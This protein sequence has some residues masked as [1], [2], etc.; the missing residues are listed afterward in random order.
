MVRGR[1]CVYMSLKEVYSIQRHVERKKKQ[2][3]RLVSRDGGQGGWRLGVDRLVRT[4]SLRFKIT[5]I[6]EF[7][8]LRVHLAAVAGERTSEVG[9][10]AALGHRVREHGRFPLISRLA[11]C[12]RSDR[13]RRARHLSVVVIGVARESPLLFGDRI[14]NACGSVALRR[15][16]RSGHGSRSADGSSS[17]A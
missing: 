13:S 7:T 9:V 16:R 5:Q 2:R 6:T 4:L 8:P 3:S 14:A 15:V 1:V 11:R 12:R 17:S 10:L